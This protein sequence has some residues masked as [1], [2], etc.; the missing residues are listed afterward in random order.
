[1]SDR[2]EA[3]LALVHKV[4]F[5]S[6][7]PYALHNG[8]ELEYDTIFKSNVTCDASL[9]EIIASRK[10]L[11]DPYAYIDD[12]GNKVGIRASMSDTRNANTI[13]FDVIS[14]KGTEIKAHVKE[15]QMSLWRK[16]KTK[17]PFDVLNPKLA[18]KFLGYEIE[19]YETLGNHKFNGFE[20]E[21]AGSIDNTQ[22]TAHLSMRFPYKTRRFTLAH[23]LGHAVLHS[24]MMMSLHRDRPV[25]TASKKRDLIEQE[26]DIFAT[27][28]LM[29]E[30]LVRKEFCARFQ[31]EKFTLSEEAA[32]AIRKELQQLD[33]LTRRELSK[34]L[35][36]SKF[37][38]GKY[39]TSLSEQFEVSIE[40]MAIRIEELFLV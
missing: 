14:D 15:L 37:Y 29:P 36:S 4:R 3:A 22:K 7:N 13:N 30:K 32:F 40:T 12:Q 28:F 31:T 16:R 8:E 26:A 33:H 24:T 1:M 39:F 5:R 34:L 27:N 10:I 9:E 23:E 25:T 6:G 21:V 17:N 11:Q 19:E 18:L 38:N 20:Y 2:K 35:A